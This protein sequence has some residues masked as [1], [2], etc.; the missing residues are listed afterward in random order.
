MRGQ[1]ALGTSK[2]RLSGLIDG[3]F[4]GILRRALSTT[5]DLL[6]CAIDHVVIDRASDPGAVAAADCLYQLEVR[7]RPVQVGSGLVIDPKDSSRSLL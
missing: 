6:P 3:R 7:R 1:L 4:A 2:M 5:P